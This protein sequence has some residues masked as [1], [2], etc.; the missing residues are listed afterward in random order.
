MSGR[1]IYL[2][3][4]HKIRRILNPALCQICGI[5]VGYGDFYCQSCQQDFSAVENSCA[6]CGLPNH[7]GG[8][9]CPLC[10]HQPPPWQQMRAPL[11]YS[12]HTRAEIHRLKYQQHI[13]VAHA[14]LQSLYPY[15]AEDSRVQVL[16]PVPLHKSRI[17]QRG[18]N[19]SEEICSILSDYLDI[20]MDRHCL[21]R[22]RATDPQSGLSP[23]KR[24]DN[25][26]RAFDYAPGRSYH[27]V[28][29]VDDVITSGSTMSEICRLLRRNGV[30]HIE[31]WSIAR[32]LKNP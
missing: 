28:A 2:N 4:R 26:R 30:K 29:I 20:P 16:I 3:I 6:L 10:L 22:V 25:I 24:R 7:A 17:L 11:V 1:R 9:V 23:G 15:F 27:A 13:Q 19:Q 21:R 14:L 32:T 18:F 12:G 31:T 8:S 5:G